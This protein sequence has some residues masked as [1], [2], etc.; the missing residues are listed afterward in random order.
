MINIVYR[1]YDEMIRG[2]AAKI[3]D[4]AADIQDDGSGQVIIYSNVF[5]WED[6]TYRDAPDPDY[7]SS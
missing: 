3:A 5:S 7:E 6:G 2:I 4:G 1:N